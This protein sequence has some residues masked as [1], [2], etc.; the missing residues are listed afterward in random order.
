MGLAPLIVNDVM[1][2]IQQINSEGVTVLLV[3]Q[4]ARKALSIARTA[5]VM[6]QGR[7]VKTGP[8]ADIS[9]DESV[10]SNYL[11]KSKSKKSSGEQIV[12]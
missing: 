12:P 7:V 8:A 3:E 5:S 10:I 2:I 6:E 9:K 4:N 1:R 11:G